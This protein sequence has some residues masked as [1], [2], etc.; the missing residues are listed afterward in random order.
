MAV[1]FTSFMQF[2]IDDNIIDIEA[3]KIQM[4]VIEKDFK[5]SN[6]FISVSLK[7]LA[8][9]ANLPWCKFAYIII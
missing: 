7:I 3:F 2:S 9:K 1:L 5:R 6:E 4:G 8:K